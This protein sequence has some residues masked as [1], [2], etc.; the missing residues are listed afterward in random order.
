MEKY[1]EEF[2]IEVNNF[3]SKMLLRLILLLIQPK[4][5]YNIKSI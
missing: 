3:F 1:V 4:I 2:I 5:D